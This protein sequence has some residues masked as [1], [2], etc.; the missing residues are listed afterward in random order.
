MNGKKERVCH[1]CGTVFLGNASKKYCSPHCQQIGRTKALS[2][3][4][5][6]KEREKRAFEK[7]EPTLRNAPSMTVRDVLRWIQRHYEKTGVLLSYGKAV[8]KIEGGR[9]K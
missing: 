7:Q 4:R 8:A 9:A 5:A 3:N 1:V 6:K 2:R